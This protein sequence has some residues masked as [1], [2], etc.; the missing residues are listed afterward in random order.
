[1]TKVLQYATLLASSALLCAA[2]AALAAPAAG[3]SAAPKSTTKTST[4]KHRMSDADFAKAAAEGGFVEV[5]LGQL[6][7]QKAANQQIKDFGKRMVTDHTKGD[8]NLKTAVSKDNL[9]VTVPSQLNAKDQ[10]TYDRLSK[11][12]GSAFDRAYARDMVRDH[13]VDVAAFRHEANDGKDASLKSF[14]ATT[15]PTLEDH[16]KQA[17]EVLRGVSPK[18]T[19]TTKTQKS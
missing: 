19:E 2:P 16:L 6:A 18:T 14:A 13:I 9:D 15:L 5:K 12:S 8:D 17:R 1:M 3:T 7:E 10:A 11:L 4:S